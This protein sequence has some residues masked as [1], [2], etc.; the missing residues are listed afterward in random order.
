MLDVYF[1]KGDKMKVGFNDGMGILSGKF[2]EIV[3]CYSRRYGYKYA[4]KRV[5]PTL[6]SVNEAIG[7]K[8]ANIWRLEPSDAY[9]Q[10]LRD[11]VQ[12]FDGMR[13]NYR[14]PLRSWS[15]LYT[16]LMYALERAYPGVD[17]RSITRQEIYD[18]DLPC[19]SIKKAVEAGLLNPVKGWEGLVSEI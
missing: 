12:A 1:L 8:S 3:Y 13:N 15:C 4:R 9:K 11:Y 16:K 17:L 18:N 19:I 6:T 2:S 7:S 5:Y 14:M 10:D